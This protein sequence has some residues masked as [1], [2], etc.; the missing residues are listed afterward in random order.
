MKSW[1]R[2]PKISEY[3]PRQRQEKNQNNEKISKFQV[4]NKRNNLN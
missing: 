3:I 2:A 1:M 4:S